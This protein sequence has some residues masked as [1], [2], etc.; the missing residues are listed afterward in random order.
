MIFAILIT[1]VIDISGVELLP[2]NEAVLLSN[3]VIIDEDIIALYEASELVFSVGSVT[4]KLSILGWASETY[5]LEV[6]DV[7]KGNLDLEMVSLFVSSHG[8]YSNQ[9]SSL[10]E[11]QGLIV[12]A[13]PDTTGTCRE[14]FNTAQE[15]WI[16]YLHIQSAPNSDWFQ[17]YPISGAK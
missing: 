8:L 9:F 14:R 17:K 7:F 10:Q 16:A 13:S 3:E 4:R 1:A 15:S 5:N 6:Q 11:G 12:L 2:L